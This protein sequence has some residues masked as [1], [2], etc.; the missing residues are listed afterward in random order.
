[1]PVGPPRSRQAR[2]REVMT[3]TLRARSEIP[4]EHT[5]DVESVFASDADWS[6][7]LAGLQAVLPDLE[8]F[9][10]RLGDGPETLARFLGLSERISRGLD[11]ISVCAVLRS[12]VDSGV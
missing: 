12:S 3:V 5:W 7:E 10:G 9:R 4:V 1:M 8:R 11:R 2:R 6:A